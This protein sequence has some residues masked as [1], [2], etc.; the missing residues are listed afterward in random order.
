MRTARRRGWIAALMLLPLA[1]AAQ[2]RSQELLKTQ[3]RA[4]GPVWR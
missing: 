4:G 1:A 2:T 3:P